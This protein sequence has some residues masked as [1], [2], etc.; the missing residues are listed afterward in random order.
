MKLFI[1][2]YTSKSFKAA[3]GRA[4]VW[5]DEGGGSRDPIHGDHG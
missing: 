5:V 1:Y 3:V 2:I 4:E